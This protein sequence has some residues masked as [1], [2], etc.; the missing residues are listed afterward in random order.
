ML[1][2]ETNSEN[3][4]CNLNSWR[5]EHRCWLVHSPQAPPFSSPKILS[6]TLNLSAQ[7]LSHLWNQL[8]E[9]LPF[10]LDDLMRFVDVSDY[11]VSAQKCSFPSFF[12]TDMWTMTFCMWWYWFFVCFEGL[13][14]W[15]STMR[16][17][18][19]GKEEYI[20]SNAQMQTL[21]FGRTVQ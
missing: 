3:S 1:I 11:S 20:N 16:K 14:N 7:Q 8:E 19:W 12:P 9:Y 17:I 4:N 13:G 18:N 15:S 10:R 2:I 21:S 5:K 6:K